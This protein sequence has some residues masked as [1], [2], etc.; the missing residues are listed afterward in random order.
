MN[1]WLWQSSLNEAATSSVEFLVGARLV[2]STRDST[3]NLS[4][5]VAVKTILKSVALDQKTERA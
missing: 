3:P 5:L 4:R 1:N 2:F